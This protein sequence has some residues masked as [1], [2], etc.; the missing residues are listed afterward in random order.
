M[1]SKVQLLLDPPISPDGF[2]M[3]SMSESAVRS[4]CQAR[5]LRALCCPI[6]MDRGIQRPGPRTR[7]VHI[8]KRANT[9]DVFGRL[10]SGGGTCRWP[11]AVGD[12]DSLSKSNTDRDL[13]SDPHGSFI[14]RNLASFPLP[15]TTSGSKDFR[16]KRQD[17][18]RHLN[19]PR[20][21]GPVFFWIG[22]SAIRAFGGCLGSKRR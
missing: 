4:D 11:L 9:R 18:L 22:S 20:T 5:L 3:S 10:P 15:R 19:R 12:E 7:T 14:D 6:L 21:K 1:R 16:P 13:M 17:G 8:V 2:E